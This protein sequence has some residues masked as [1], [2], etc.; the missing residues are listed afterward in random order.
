MSQAPDQTSPF[1]EPGVYVHVHVPGTGAAWS[2][3]PEATWETLSEIELLLTTMV[4]DLG[5]AIL[6]VPGDDYIIRFGRAA[7]AVMWSARMQEGLLALDLPNLGTDDA[8]SPHLMA[9]MAIHNGSE[10]ALQQLSA[11][12]QAGQ[13]LISDSAWQSITDPLPPDLQVRSLGEI[14]M[15][16]QAIP[17]HQVTTRLLSRRRFGEQRADRMNIPHQPDC[18]VGRKAAMADLSERL[19][20]GARLVN[21]TGD[22]GIGKTRIAMQSIRNTVHEH[23]GGVALVSLR[24]V[25]D[26][27]ELLLATAAALEMALGAEQHQS[28]AERIGH[29]IASRGRSILLLDD[30]PPH[31]TPSVLDTWVRTAT[32]TKILVTSHQPIQSERATHLHLGPMNKADGRILFLARTHRVQ[33]GQNRSSHVAQVEVSEEVQS[34]VASAIEKAAGLGSPRWADSDKSLLALRRTALDHDAPAETRVRCALELCPM[35]SRMGLGDVAH[36]MLES[37]HDAA[38]DAALTN[39]WQ[40]AM[41]DI[42]L[43]ARDFNHLR[44][45][46]EKSEQA[47]RNPEQRSDWLLRKGRLALEEERFSDAKALLDQ[48]AELGQSPAI[49]HAQ[50][51]SLA[52]MDE[53][54]QAVPWLEKASQNLNDPVQ[55]T[56][57]LIDLGRVLQDLGRTTKSDM[58]F[59]EAAALGGD[60]PPILAL[61]HHHRFQGA[62]ARLE[63]NEAREHLAQELAYRKRCGDQTGH[64]RAHI[65]SGLLDLVQHD[66]SSANIH[67]D[68]ALELCRGAGLHTIEAQALTFHGI[69]AR[70]S[71]DFGTAL[72]AFVEAAALSEE[73]HEMLAVIHSHRGAVEA[74]CDALDNADAAF[75][76]AETHLEASWDALANTIHDVLMGFVD[77]ARA[78][79]AALVENA[80]AEAA[81]IDSALNRLARGS[82][83]ET[84]ST[85]PRG[86]EIPSRLNELRLA[87]LLLDGALSNLEPS[88]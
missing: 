7:P 46:I 41:A 64:A 22:E 70:L 25:Q 65:Q 62:T 3:N 43:D 16:G 13:V 60:E 24:H 85:P 81:H 72:D 74:A 33:R 68:A 52:A 35:L 59:A 30:F 19:D 40:C 50:G 87:R 71:G 20:A 8:Q 45:F 88:E 34:G 32:E 28:I 75:A 78:R 31:I 77:L 82:S 26:E 47:E 17:V 6:S 56:H 37:L 86:R 63:L 1:D 67:F 23:H 10:R 5:G 27:T 49:D 80:S 48:A 53:W 11:Q 21:I 18:F 58:A 55:R 12:T 83:F 51:Q 73:E 2:N 84:R 36:S 4:E 69:A 39:E 38:V 42:M 76:V 54:E 9:S 29:A 57:A 15:V 66:P 14:K 61:I 44:A 79:D